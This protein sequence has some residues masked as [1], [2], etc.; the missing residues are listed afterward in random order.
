MTTL[1]QCTLCSE[2]MSAADFEANCGK[3]SGCGAGGEEF[4]EIEAGDCNECE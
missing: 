3:C 4:V 2:V 1:F